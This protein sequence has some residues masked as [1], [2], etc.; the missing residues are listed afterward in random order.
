MESTELQLHWNA[1]C[2]WIRSNGV[3]APS[4]ET[5]Y[6]PAFA[7]AFSGMWQEDLVTVYQTYRSGSAQKQNPYQTA[8]TAHYLRYRLELAGP[9]PE[10]VPARMTYL[11]EL[12]H[13]ARKH[14]ID[15]DV[16]LDDVTQVPGDGL[17]SFLQASSLRSPKGKLNS[18]G[19]HYYTQ[20]QVLMEQ[21]EE[22][23]RRGAVQSAAC[24]A[25]KRAQPDVRMFR[26]GL[27]GAAEMLLEGWKDKPGFPGSGTQQKLL[28]LLSLK[29]PRPQDREALPENDYFAGVELFG[30]AS[31]L[32]LDLAAELYASNGAAF[33]KPAIPAGQD[34]HYWL[35]LLVLAPFQRLERLTADFFLPADRTAGPES[36]MIS[37]HLMRLLQNGLLWLSYPPRASYPQIR[38][39]PCAY[40]LLVGKETALPALLW[41]PRGSY[42]AETE[43]RDASEMALLR[44]LLQR[45]CER[46][47]QLQAMDAQALGPQSLWTLDVFQ[48]AP[49]LALILASAPQ[50]E[51]RHRS[52][53]GALL[54]VQIGCHWAQSCGHELE[55]IHTA[56][57][58]LVHL[59]EH[60][61]DSFAHAAAAGALP[62]VTIP[63]G[64]ADMAA[65]LQW[66]HAQR[67][68]EELDAQAQPDPGGGGLKYAIFA[69]Q[70]ARRSL[71]AASRANNGREVIRSACAQLRALLYELQCMG[72][73]GISDATA[74]LDYLTPAWQLLRLC[75]E[76]LILN[77]VGTAY[78]TILSPR[79]FPTDA[80][81]SLHRQMQAEISAAAVRYNDAANQFFSGRS[82]ETLELLRFD[83]DASLEQLKQQAD[84][85]K[86]CTAGFVRE[87]KT[88]LPA[89][90]PMDT[91]ASGAGYRNFHQNW[92]LSDQDSVFVTTRENIELSKQH[93]MSHL[94]SAQNAV[95]TVNQ[96]MDSLAVREMAQNPAF[97]WMIKMGK[98]GV[99]LYG[100]MYD[101]VQYAAKQ[102]M[103]A[104]G[105]G[106]K[107]F[108]WS[109]LPEAFNSSMTARQ[110][111]AEYLRGSRRE[112]D[113]SH[114]FRDEIVFFADS[115]RIL[116]EAI[117]YDVRNRHFQR[118]GS[119]NMIA[120]MNDN[121]DW[122]DQQGREPEVCMVHREI[123]G[124]V[125]PGG[126]RTDYQYL[127]DL[128]RK[129]DGAEL[130]VP[131]GKLLELVSGFADPENVLDKAQFLLNDL[132]N[133]MLANTFTQF[134]DFSYTQQQRQLLRYDETKPITSGGCVLY[135]QA[136]TLTDTGIRVD[137]SGLV[138]RAAAQ[139][140]IIRMH[141][142]LRPEDM[143][144]ILADDAVEY[145]I[146]ESVDGSILR[147]GRVVLRTDDADGTDVLLEL[148]GHDK[149]LHME[150]GKENH[151]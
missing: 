93:L 121:Y 66:Y 110:E 13:A 76:Q 118:K 44:K 100:D 79:A 131:Q 60:W 109:S 136:H 10:V 36:R 39:I 7:D 59:A 78:R 115:L 101:L 106:R 134:A 58:R 41:K 135:H 30:Y 151:T 38:L 4:S 75:A 112:S 48:P 34:S 86:A 23:H 84:S 65:W 133:R 125:G 81:Q 107:P 102:M 37:A 85:I 72:Q 116:N 28:Q 12:F 140:A 83:S 138:D 21:R 26:K 55:S 130:T 87:V 147:T 19:F 54:R 89:Q 29:L 94:L 77:R 53:V 15:L 129:M 114:A 32:L 117:P 2:A 120:S 6:L 57:I 97:L 143:V 80:A 27:A 25:W 16:F 14:S 51:E 71:A 119:P 11:R 9:L 139:D 69:E 61:G 64:I 98:V 123:C 67:I 96:L 42:S 148:I 40:R 132:Y 63:H 20:R 43:R 103:P 33:G 91:A 124:I 113:L 137:W 128:C 99:S 122:L 17:N 150:T 1:F 126:F 149:T 18:A 50:R 111:A 45:L 5:K 70:S 145:D 74:V 105:S 56:C 144:R 127:L 22:L 82:A 146:Q 141:P 35:W 73:A 104:S 108:R 49:E 62:F 47:T 24:E 68:L 90:R 52:T 142:G 88:A 31:G 46:L 95:F 92:F 3:I 8:M